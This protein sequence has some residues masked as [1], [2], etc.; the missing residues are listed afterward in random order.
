MRYKIVYLSI[1]FFCLITSFAI[2][3]VQAQ[4]GSG[5][6]EN[7]IEEIKE[8]RQQS[9]YDSSL[10]L[11]EKVK[12]KY[13]LG[14]AENISLSIL[15][16]S[17]Y[18]HLGKYDQ[19]DDLLMELEK[20]QKFSEDQYYYVVFYKAI[21]QSRKGMYQEAIDL[22]IKAAKGFKKS[23]DMLF[24]SNAYNSLGVYFKEL[25]DFSSAQFY[26][27]LS[28]DVNKTLK[29]DN[30]TLQ[31]LNNLGSLFSS[32]QQ[33]DSAL[34]YY[35]LVSKLLEKNKNYF[36]LAQNTLNRGNLY[37]KKGNYTKAEILFKQ[38]LTICE[39]EG[40]SYG[41][42]LA[43]LNLGNLYRLTGNFRFSENYLLD[44]L[45]MSRTQQMKKEEVKVLERISWLKRDQN[46]FK[47]AYE[48]NIQFHALNDS[49]VND[50]IRKESSELMNKFESE[51]RNNEILKLTSE[52]QKGQLYLLFLS[53]VLMALVVIALLIYLS[54]KKTKFQ[55]IVIEKEKVNLQKLIE[56]KDK[57]FTIQAAQLLKFYSGIEKGKEKVFQVLQNEFPDMDHQKKIQISNKFDVDFIGDGMIKDFDARIT[58]SNEDF[59]K[60]LLSHYSD[61]TLSELK[62]CA[63]LRLNLSTK[64]I[65]EILNK[66]TRTL[67]T[68]RLS[69]RKKMKL[70]STENLVSH[71]IA[72][73]MQ[74]S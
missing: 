15:E 17:N 26:F 70:E 20:N 22:M 39:R 5:E 74:A 60:M 43:K 14:N 6:L 33:L 73:E 29:N 37:E 1:S 18:Y 21:S 58:D 35:D 3:C 51:K 44:A 24:L 23:N 38:C 27:Q 50:K 45:E 36:F 42:L 4:S 56:T 54:H 2:P 49:L 66:S 16:I 40:F 12:I 9:Y 71:L 8:L 53:L 11:I 52:K 34:Y 68:Q 30:L 57:E 48:F 19:M 7:L 32:L 13:G 69:I 64:E 72:L 25:N 31:N 28:R 46:N 67:E 65:S 59:F 41:V 55:K 10:Q 61:L 63:Y 47:E 62:L